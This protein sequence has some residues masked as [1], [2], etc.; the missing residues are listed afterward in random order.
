MKR[1][2]LALAMV[3]GMVATGIAT[4]SSA[5]ARPR[6]W[7]GGRSYYNYGYRPYYRPNYGGYYR[8]YS[9]PRYYGNYYGNY[10]YPRSYYRGGYYPGYYGGY[11][12][13]SPGVGLSWG[14]GGV[15]FY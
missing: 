15:Y 13:G 5:D 3:A 8:T 6:G 14:R 1:I 7:Y 12:Y 4:P 11:R 2:L 9:Y 10:Y